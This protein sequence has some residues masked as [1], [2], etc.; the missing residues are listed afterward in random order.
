LSIVSWLLKRF[1]KEALQYA[2][3]LG[4][5]YV[6]EVATSVDDIYGQSWHPSGRQYNPDDLAAKKGG[7]SIYKKMREDD[8]VKAALHLKKSAIIH[9]GW[10]IEGDEEKTNDY[11]EAMISNIQGNMED[12]VRSIMSAYEYGFSVHEKVY[13]IFEA[14][15]FKGKIG[16]SALKQKSPTRFDFDVDEYGRIKP[17]GLLQR[18][19]SGAIKRLNPDKF[20]L[21]TYQREFDN[22]YGESD[23]KAA[24]RFW[25][26]KVN[27]FKYWGMYL[28]KFAIPFVWGKVTAPTVSATDQTLFR[29]IVSNIQAGMAAVAPDNLELNFIETSK[30]GKDTFQAAIDA[31]DIRISRAILMPTLLGLSAGQKEGSLARSQTEADTFDLILGGDSRQVEEVLNEQLIRPLIE[32][33]FGM[34]DEYPKFRFKPMR[35]EDKNA[36]VSAWADAVQKGAATSTPETQEHLRS[37]LGFPEATDAE[38]KAMLEDKEEP[39]EEG[40]PRLRGKGSGK[41]NGAD[42][43]KV[44]VL[45]TMNAQEA[46]KAWKEHV[47]ELDGL[48]E[49]A[50]AALSEAFGKS[51]DA[52]A[53]DAKKKSATSNG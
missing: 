40:V 51:I 52:L 39:E 49:E 8:Q 15:P 45:T 22:Y 53:V 4:P 34:M 46:R 2:A 1:E 9:P 5:R 33:N 19:Q 41:G 24:Y 28:E 26:L 11:S 25:F 29:T 38:K 43:S 30:S 47:D 23:L 18:Q 37:L 31:C 16:I 6:G 36:F 12:S 7:L 17:N 50:K 10:T 42:K 14:G 13:E 35:E 20:I 32:M 21:H 48:E 27:F 3:K 44:Y